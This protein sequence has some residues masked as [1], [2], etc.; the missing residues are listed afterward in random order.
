MSHCRGFTLI[1]VLISWVILT[2]VLFSMVALQATNTRQLYHHYLETIAII[3][4]NNMFE[5]LR[6]N[7]DPSFRQREWMLWN[8][9]NQLVLPEGNGRYVC[10]EKICTV[11]LQ[12]Q[13]RREEHL[14]LMSCI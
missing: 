9:Q 7:Q 14:E 12:W 1:E 6:A 3:Q 10:S 5:R 2:A 13:E 4:I 8:E 11:S